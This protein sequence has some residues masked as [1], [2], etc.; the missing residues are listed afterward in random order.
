MTILK[1]NG[2]FHLPLK[3]VLLSRNSWRFIQKLEISIHFWNQAFFR[4]TYDTWKNIGKP[5]SSR[6]CRHEFWIG[7]KF[8]VSKDGRCANRTHVPEQYPTTASS[9]LPRICLHQSYP[10]VTSHSPHH[11]ARGSSGRWVRVGPK[12]GFRCSWKKLLFLKLLKCRNWCET[13]GLENTMD[14]L[15]HL[16]ESLISVKKPTDNEFSSGT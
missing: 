10:S 9:A 8:L 5:N 6:Y 13:Y 14:E 7:E 12:D 11:C 3:T 1:E 4:N 2:P 15:E 16:L